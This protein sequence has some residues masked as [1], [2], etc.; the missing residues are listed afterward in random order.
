MSQVKKKYKLLFA[1]HCLWFHG[2]KDFMKKLK[3]GMDDAVK[4][5]KSREK[6][7]RDFKGI[8]FLGWLVVFFFS[9]HSMIYTIIVQS[10]EDTK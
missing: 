4:G 3:S 10:Y 5:I 1:Y 2:A 7:L 6:L 8:S 9:L